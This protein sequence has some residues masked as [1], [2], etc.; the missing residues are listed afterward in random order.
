MF[1]NYEL[2]SVRVKQGHECQRDQLV[3]RGT[4]TMNDVKF[5]L[6]KDSTQSKNVKQNRMNFF[7][8]SR[9]VDCKT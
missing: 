7:Q 3:V 8:L 4:V 2:G 1:C 5:M 9:K 6:F